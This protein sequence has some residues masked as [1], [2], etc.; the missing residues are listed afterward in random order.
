MGVGQAFAFIGLVAT[1]VLQGVFS[2]GLSKPQ[3]ILSFVDYCGKSGIAGFSDWVC[4]V[5]LVSNRDSTIT[6]QK[7][8]SVPTKTR[9]EKRIDR[10][11]QFFSRLPS[12]KL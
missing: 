12:G 3:W 1:I 7:S 6:Q 2:G 9:T 10:A 5:E 4:P 11:D 8:F